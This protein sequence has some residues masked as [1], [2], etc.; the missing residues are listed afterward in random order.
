M[1][2]KDSQKT[3]SYDAND[4]GLGILFCIYDV[5]CQTITSN[6]HQ[7]CR[8]MRLTSGRQMKLTFLWTTAL[9]FAV[10]ISSPVETRALTNGVIIITTRNDQDISYGGGE[11]FDQKG[12]GNTAP[13]DT[14]MVEL[15]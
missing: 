8:A 5:D 2:E 9:A 13:G 14:A 11:V 10:M 4:R 15:L 3:R 6:K 1:P 12:P 7:T